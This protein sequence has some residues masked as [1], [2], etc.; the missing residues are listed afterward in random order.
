MLIGLHG[1][2]RAGKD[3][4]YER[5]CH[6]ID[7]AIRV[8]FADKLKIS[9][10]RSLGLTGSDEYL[11][12]VANQFKDNGRM[13][14]DLGEGMGSSYEMS[15]RQYLQYFGTQGHRQVF[16]SDFW[17]DMALDPIMDD[18]AGHELVT[19]V[20]T[21]CRFPNEAERIKELG[22]EIWEIVDTQSSRSG[23]HESEHRLPNELIDLT[24]DNTI[25]N[26]NFANLDEEIKRALSVRQM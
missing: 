3:T 26:D 21:D 19:I 23:K 1:K 18:N 5:I 2:M 24:I 17:V 25:R 8:A 22:G 20:A 7:G 13:I 11:I 10:M 14:I 16:G 4:T 9:A 12:L 6:I 15:G